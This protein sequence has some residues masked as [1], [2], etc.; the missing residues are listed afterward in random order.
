MVA[1]GSNLRMHQLLSDADYRRMGSRLETRSSHLAITLNC[2]KVGGMVANILRRPIA[3]HKE[4]PAIGSCSASSYQTCLGQ[5]TKRIH[6]SPA[7]ILHTA[8]LAQVD[9]S[10]SP[11]AVLV[12]VSLIRMPTSTE[13]ARLGNPSEQPSRHLRKLEWFRHKTRCPRE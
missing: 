2:Q 6:E 3:S 9:Q 8:I 11:A 12:S 4:C 10:N 13:P 7:A 5:G 1:P